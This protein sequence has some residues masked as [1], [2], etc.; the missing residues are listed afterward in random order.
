MP[1]GR[2]AITRQFYDLLVEGFRQNPGNFTRAAKFAGCDP[3]M[4]K[5][6]WEEGWQKWRGLAFA[7]PIREIIAEEEAD[8]QQVAARKAAEERKRVADEGN[9]VRQEQLDRKGQMLNMLKAIRVAMGAGLGSLQ[10]F[11][12]TLARVMETFPINPQEI[13]AMP[14]GKRLSLMREFVRATNMVTES[15]ERLDKMSR[16]DNEQPTE[17][18]GF[19]PVSLADAAREIEEAKAMLDLMR[20][21]GLIEATVDDQQLTPGNG[22]N[23]SSNGHGG[24]GALSH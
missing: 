14:A 3:R 21:E 24:N 4:S 1:T 5:R 23:G 16:L 20:T 13:A 7:R 15:Y 9:L 8:A 12:V 18:L 11:G 19:E 22:A 10:R 6:G 2:R 17:I